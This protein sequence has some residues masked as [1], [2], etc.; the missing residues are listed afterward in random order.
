MKKGLIIGLIAGAAAVT[1]AAIFRKKKNGCYC[2]DEEFDEEF[3][4]DCCSDCCD[5]DDNCNEIPADKT[6]EGVIV[7]DAC[8]AYG[9]SEEEALDALDDEVE[10]NEV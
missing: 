2:C 3:D 6:E 5:C 1:A 4:C 10:S 7:T 8:V 9:N